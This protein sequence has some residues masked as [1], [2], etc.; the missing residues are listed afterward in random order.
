[1][2]ILNT[3]NPILISTGSLIL[4][5]ALGNG[6][7][8][9]GSIVEILGPSASGKT[10]LCLSILAEAAKLGE[11]CAF[12]DADQSLTITQLRT[13][14]VDLQH[15]YISQTS[16][17]EQALGIMEH[18]IRSQA[19]RIIVLDSI[20]SLVPIAEST[21]EFSD[22]PTNLL[23]KLFSN[24]LSKIDPILQRSQTI[25]LLTRSQPSSNKTVYHN[26]SQNT[27]RLAT[28]LHASILM[29]LESPSNLVENMRSNGWRVLVNL[30][31]NKFGPCPRTI[32]LD[33]MYND[34][35]L[36]VGE[37]FDLGLQLQIIKNLPGHYLY[38]S[39]VLGNSKQESL[40]FLK[41]SLLVSRKIEEEIRQKIFS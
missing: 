18:L 23:D 16:Q 21:S 34:G 11:Y 5:I 12:I 15:S 22:A 29:Q 27:A 19:I 13:F 7:I 1:M 25:L 33:I 36:K 30:K 35:I 20:D 39:Q 32:K 9:G 3:D 2:T 31:K 37:I 28:K 38:Q 8:P 24:F 4:D 14:G 26:L 40:D 6:G 17:A 41:S 10:S